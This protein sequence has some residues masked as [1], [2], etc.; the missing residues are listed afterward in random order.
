MQGGAGRGD[1]GS[2]GRSDP[3][4]VA[5]DAFLLPLKGENPCCFPP[6]SCTPR[7]L[8]EVLRQQVSITLV[9]PDWRQHEGRTSTGFYSNLLSCY[10]ATQSEEPVR[11]SLT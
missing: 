11:P 10:R 1:A 8:Q 5:V 7:L 6:V 9:A 4:A 2:G 3:P